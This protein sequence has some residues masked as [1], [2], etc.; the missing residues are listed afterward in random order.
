MPWVGWLVGAL[1]PVIVM[2]AGDCYCSA[3]RRQDLVGRD[4]W[5]RGEMNRHIFPVI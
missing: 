4:Y 2:G 5:L 1:R 3:Y